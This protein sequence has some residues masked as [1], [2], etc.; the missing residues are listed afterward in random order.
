MCEN[1][2]CID[3]RYLLLFFVYKIFYVV[4]SDVVIVVHPLFFAVLKHDE[5]ICR[6]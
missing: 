2:R 4:K 3:A 5:L 1:H 6:R